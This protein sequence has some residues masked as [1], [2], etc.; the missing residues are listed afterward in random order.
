MVRKY[1][2][3]VK[4]SKGSTYDMINAIEDRIEELESFYDEDLFDESTHI[5]ESDSKKWL[6]TEVT[7]DEYKLLK[8]FLVDNNIKHE[9]SGAYNMIH[10]EVYVDEYEKKKV[11]DFLNTLDEGYHP[12][13]TKR[14]SFNKVRRKYKLG[15][16]SRKKYTQAQLRA[17]VRDG[18]AEDITNYSFEEANDLYDRGYDVI[19]VS[20]GTY[21]INGAL[22]RMRDTDELLVI[23]SRNSTLLQLV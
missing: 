11:N 15:E 10:V 4:E 18:K 23:T 17:M 3:L 12:R 16:S 7:E 14:E 19:G 6:N 5:K 8:K 22:L 20:S 9:A 1:K 13:R 21:G 2:K